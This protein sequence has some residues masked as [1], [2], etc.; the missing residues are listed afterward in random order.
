MEERPGTHRGH[1]NFFL[2]ALA[3]RSSGSVFLQFLAVPVWPPAFTAI[4]HVREFHSGNEIRG[5]HPPPAGSLTFVGHGRATVAE[6]CGVRD[7]VTPGPSPSKS[8]TPQIVF[9]IFLLIEVS[10]N[11]ALCCI[12]SQSRTVCGCGES[13]V[14]LSEPRYDEGSGDHHTHS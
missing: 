2:V 13:A 12:S 9:L 5:P 1:I 6:G 10:A 4:T 11:R 7:K 14:L 3:T 8:S